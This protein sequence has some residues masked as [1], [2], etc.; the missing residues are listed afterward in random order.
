MAG[1]AKNLIKMFMEQKTMHPWIKSNY[2]HDAW[3][4]LQ[5]HQQA[6]GKNDV[7]EQSI[8]ED[9]LDGLVAV[10]Q[11]RYSVAARLPFRD[12]NGELSPEEWKQV[13]EQIITNLREDLF[14]DSYRKGLAAARVLENLLEGKPPPF[15]LAENNFDA[16]EIQRLGARYPHHLKNLSESYR[17]NGRDGLADGPKAKG[18]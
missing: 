13:Y 12:N 5:R 11:L 4:T 6:V 7:G 8:E 1:K 3:E 15:F 14:G 2:G 17:A 18:K 16:R 10:D 9:T